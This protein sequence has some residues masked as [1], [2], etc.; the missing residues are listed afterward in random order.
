MKLKEKI[1]RKLDGARGRSFSGEELAEEFGVSRN[2]VWKAVKS[3][4]AEGFAIAAVPNRGYSLAAEN[5]KL[6]P[7]GV[8]KFL[9]G[10]GY[11]ISVAESTGSV[12]DDLKG[13]AAKGAP[14]WSVLIAEEQTA[15]R[16]R[17]GRPFY[18][19]RGAGLYIGILLRPKLSA[20]ET[21]FI[22]TSA[23]VAVCEA[24]ESVSGE[25]ASVKWVNDVFLR[26][27]KACGIL[28]EASFNVESGGLDHAVVGIG[29][30][31]KDEAFPLELQPI[32]TSVFQGRECPAETR[33]KLAAELLERFRFY[34]E[35]IPQRTFFPQYKQRS[36]VIGRRVAVRS[37]NLNSSA[38]VLDI[39]ENCFLIVRFDD[40]TI[41]RL[42]GGEISIKL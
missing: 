8:E 28:T 26:G 20:A 14:A 34:C 18:S 16:G 42:S 23:A 21:L 38:E 33:A 30:N 32:A 7:S 19:P 4:Q 37:G 1:Y 15:G 12:L 40:G 24:I 5:D 10:G 36:F 35:G 31:V 17:F 9:A 22:T 6:T 13:S 27:K 39:D 41:H 11:Q 29:I 2:A 3:L 25:S